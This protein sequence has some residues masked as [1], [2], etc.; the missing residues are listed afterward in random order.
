MLGSGH[1]T[2]LACPAQEMGNQVKQLNTSNHCIAEF[3]RIVY[4]T[5][6]QAFAL[7]DQL[8]IGLRMLTTSLCP[9]PNETE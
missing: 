2:Q 8:F 4:T 9:V 1:R 6:E 7:I 5:I 3:S